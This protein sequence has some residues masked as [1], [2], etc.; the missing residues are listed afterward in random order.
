MVFKPETLGTGW[1]IK[2]IKRRC[3]G[4]E[5]ARL[6]WWN[7]LPIPWDMGLDFL[8][9][10]LTSFWCS[11]RREGS[12]SSASMWGEAFGV[13]LAGTRQSTYYSKEWGLFSEG[14]CS[15]WCWAGFMTT[16][17]VAVTCNIMQIDSLMREGLTSAGKAKWR[18]VG[19]KEVSGAKC[20]LGITAGVTP[21]AE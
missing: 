13:R 9:R 20:A 10:L 12:G 4:S 11:F 8:T 5:W 2:V 7:S 6:K 15:W 1:F 16:F 19:R 21:R 14:S 18:E 3:R 17:R